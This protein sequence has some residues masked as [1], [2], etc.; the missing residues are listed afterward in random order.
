MTPSL[1]N[2]SIVYATMCCAV[3]FILA[4]CATAPEAPAHADNPLPEGPAETV[5]AEGDV[6]DIRFLYWPELNEV[7]TIRADG[8]ITLQMVNDVV[9]A[10]MRPEKLREALLDL[11]SDKLR[12]PEI[13]VIAR[14]EEN[15]RVY[16]GG[17]VNAFRNTDGLVEIP[18]T[19]RM[20]VM[21]AIL[22][23]GG[24]LEESAKISQVLVI[25][26]LDDV[27]YVRTVDLR[28]LFKESEVEAFYLQP[29][30]IVY[31]PRTNIDRINQWADQYLDQPVPDWIRANLDL[32]NII[33][34]NRG[35]RPASTITYGPNGVTIE[36]AR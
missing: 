8:M 1:M 34:N 20:T 15:R 23:A 35:Q 6:V 30:D 19:G 18:L 2:R 25:R 31:V 7:Q 29:N 22:L 21:E 36:E 14:I 11:Y 10:G 26:R 24:L 32:N 3:V 13:T 28:P 12:D 5:L 16:V 9:A 4:G 17:E 27:Q 33:R